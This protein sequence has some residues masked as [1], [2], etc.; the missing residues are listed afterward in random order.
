MRLPSIRETVAGF[1][2]LPNPHLRLSPYWQIC[3]AYQ[4]LSTSPGKWI[5][6][7]TRANYFDVIFVATHIAHIFLCFF[8]NKGV[9]LKKTY[10]KT[11]MTLYRLIKPLKASLRMAFDKVNL[12]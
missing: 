10:R 2:F 5:A 4:T 12:R 6:L 3:N 9:D 7:E 1:I 11:L 8:Q